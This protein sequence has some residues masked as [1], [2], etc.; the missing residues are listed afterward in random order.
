M[1]RAGEVDAESE[2]RNAYEETRRADENAPV[3]EK[4]ARAGD[5][6]RE[7]AEKSRDMGGR[8]RLPKPG[9]ALASASTSARRENLKSPKPPEEPQKA[10]KN[11]TMAAKLKNRGVE[12]NSSK[13][14]AG[15]GGGDSFEVLKRI[16]MQLTNLVSSTKAN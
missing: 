16:E 11:S 13:S 8:V 15:A 1:R 6:L 3:S 4:R 9:G 5:A 7:A 14:S 10:G 2:E 12:A